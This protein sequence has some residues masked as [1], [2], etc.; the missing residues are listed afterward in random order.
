MLKIRTATKFLE[1]G[2]VV[3]EVSDKLG[4]TSPAYF[5]SCFKRITGIKPSEIKK[6]SLK[7]FSSFMS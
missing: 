1:E 6:S 4:F 5:S 7:S 2:M 3:S